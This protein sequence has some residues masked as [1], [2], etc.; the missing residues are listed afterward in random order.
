MTQ[1]KKLAFIGS[2]VMA[3][4]MIKGLLQRELIHPHN[5]SCSDPQA[6]RLEFLA[7]RYGVNTSSDNAKALAG[8][9][10]GVLSIK[11]QMFA[12][13]GPELAGALEPSALLL[14]IM[15]GVTTGNIVRRT[16]HKPVVRV[17]PNTP[18]QVGLGVSVWCCTRQVSESQREVTT[19]ILRA[20]GIEHQVKREEMLDMATAL[21]GS[22]PAY[23]FLFMEALIDAG[24][25]LGFSRQVAKELVVQTVKGTAEYAAQSDKHIADLR[26]MVTS[27]GGTTADAL[28][29]L[30]KGGLR[31]MLSKAVHAAFV[32]SQ[33]LSK[34]SEED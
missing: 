3:E 11:P 26:N 32:K 30:E 14:S 9:D 18:A 5:V 34:L 1:D 33:K 25:H 22:A 29:H 27:P 17:M 10:V 21:S 4:A 16:R 28:Y 24:V 12:E 15:A 19:Q 20:L 23:V 6:Q 8:A 13:V 2:G 7:H 31:T